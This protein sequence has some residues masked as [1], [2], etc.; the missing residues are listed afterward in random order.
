M[1][2]ILFNDISSGK[3]Y[4]CYQQWKFIKARPWDLNKQLQNAEWK[5][6]QLKASTLSNLFEASRQVV[7]SSAAELRLNTTPQKTL[8]LN[9]I[10]TRK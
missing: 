5:K 9:E 2:L 6:N 1:L 3:I 8:E 7:E 4:F 10:Q